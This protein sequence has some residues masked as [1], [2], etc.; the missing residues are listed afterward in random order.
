M[1]GNYLEAHT[2]CYICDDDGYDNFYGAVTHSTCCFKGALTKT[3][4]FLP[5]S[6]VWMH[7]TPYSSFLSKGLKGL[8]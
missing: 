6:A 3:R 4:P 8:Y 5:S 7:W 2:M 1:G